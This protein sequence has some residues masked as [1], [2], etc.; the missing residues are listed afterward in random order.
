MLWIIMIL[1][2][3]IYSVYEYY[4]PKIRRISLSEHQRYHAVPSTFKGKKVLFISD[5]QFDHKLV[6]FDHFA[7]RRVMK[8]I[9]SLDP[10]LLILGGDLIHDM[11]PFNHYVFDYLSQL[12]M[13]KI[14]VLGNHDYLDLET[15]YEKAD[16]AKIRILKNEG[17]IWSDILWFG[18]DD[19]RCGRP[20]VSKLHD[21][22]YT[23]LLSHNPDYAEKI[24]GKAIDLLLAGHYHAGQITFFSLWAPAVRSEYG[25]RYRYGYVKTKDKDVYVS[26]GIGGKVFIFPFRF[27]ARPELVLIEY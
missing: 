7:M 22:R 9:R 8:K 25:Q 18:V 3:M 19:Y 24:A 10:D 20:S 21:E 27:F 16:E 4:H 13:V 5:F 26:S 2:A 1:F 17:F 12:E 23:V 6:G 14:M 11:N 15:V